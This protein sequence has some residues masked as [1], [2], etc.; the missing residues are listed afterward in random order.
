[1][2]TVATETRCLVAIL[3]TCVAFLLLTVW[4]LLPGSGLPWV[5][6]TIPHSIRGW[7]RTV[8]VLSFRLRLCCMPIVPEA[9]VIPNSFVGSPRIPS[10]TIP[11][12][13][14]CALSARPFAGGMLSIVCATV[15]AV[16]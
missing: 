3:C 4:R 8:F 1:M 7:R 13:G 16:A 15:P 5:R 11:V 10:S 9:T 14:S 2:L 12:L 6:G